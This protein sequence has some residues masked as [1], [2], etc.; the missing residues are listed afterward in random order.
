[1]R[2]LPI[3]SCAVCPAA[4][5]HGWSKAS[6]HVVSCPLGA[7]EARRM[8]IP[9]GMSRGLLA[10]PPPADCPARADPL[11]YAPRPPQKEPAP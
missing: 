6:G 1:M 3:D 11:V 8:T 9:P 5:F 10:M 7:Q 2:H 4:K